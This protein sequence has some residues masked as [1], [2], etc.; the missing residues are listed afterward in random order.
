[1]TSLNFTFSQGQILDPQATEK[2]P[3]NKPMHK[4]FMSCLK[5]HINLSE[6]LI[7]P[8]VQRFNLKV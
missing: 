1:M 7:H 8:L 2:P 6:R 5:D 3:E 4:A